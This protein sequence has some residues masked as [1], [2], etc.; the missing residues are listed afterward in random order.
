DRLRR[1]GLR[2]GRRDFAV[3]HAAVFLLRRHP[4]F[5]DALHAVRALLHDAARTDRDIGIAHRL[6]RRRV[7]VGVVE[8]VEAANLVRAVVRAVARA[9]AAVVGHVVQTFAAVRRGAN[10]ADRLARRVL[11]LHAR[12]G[13]VVDLGI[14][15]VAAV[16]AIDA[17]P[18]H[19]ALAPHFVLADDRDVVLRL[20]GDHAAV[21]AGADRRVDDHAP[22]VALVLVLRPHRLVLFFVL[23]FALREVRIL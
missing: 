14:R 12:H 20:A 5:V 10:R 11:A 17:D 16:V 21:A 19:L 23:L 4:R 2:A 15:D 7:V 3:A 22:G 9:D 1:T 8:E 13:L 6:E 18:V